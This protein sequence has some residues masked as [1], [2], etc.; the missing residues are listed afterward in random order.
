MSLD[1]STLQITVQEQ[2][3]WRRLMNVTVPAAIVRQEERRAAQQLASRARMK[4]FR[5]GRVP[6]RM[7]ESR[8]AGALR[9]EALDKL[10]GDAYRQALA[11]ENLR[12]ISEGELEDVRYEPDAD[13]QFSIA[14]DVQPS[15]ELTRLGGFVL[16]RPTPR[17]TD[18]HVQEVLAR[19]RQQAGVWKPEEKGTPGDG[20]LVSVRIARLEEGADEGGR[21]YDLVLGQGDAIPD[22]EAAIKT[23]EPGASGEFDVS[24][25]DDF[26]D[27]S[28][29]GQGERVRIDLVSRRVM[30]LPELDDDLARQ[31]GDFETL[32][33]LTA[34]VRQDLEREADEQA[35]SVVRGRLLELEL[36]LEANPFEVPL[37][38]VD[39]YADTILGEQKGIPQEKLPELRE[40]IRP[41]A[42]RVVKR[43]VLIDRI[44]DTQS[45]RATEDEIDAR[46]E[47]IAKANDTDPAKVYAGLQKAGRIEQLEHELTERKVFDFLKD[48]SE[49]TEAPAA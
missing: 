2:E 5:K 27:E 47:E 44:A 7:I 22:I 9:R 21:E 30:E 32:D 38:M 17:V 19:I 25:P 6:S 28:R 43:I 26:P 42:E 24:F 33:D 35:E 16:E 18:E 12:P 31:V 46:V 4:G 8:F 15:I 41:E 48:Q 36:V 11:T 20:D 29:R 49:I 23:L 10:I 45:L 14:F 40:Q 1:A 39:R 13:L 34:K 3:R 37:T